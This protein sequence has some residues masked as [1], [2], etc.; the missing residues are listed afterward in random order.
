[1]LKIHIILVYVILV[2]HVLNSY[3]ISQLIFY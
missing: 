2:I 1:M 3:R